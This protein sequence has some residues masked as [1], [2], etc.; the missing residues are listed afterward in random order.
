MSGAA[1]VVV[2][3]TARVSASAGFQ[4][5]Q[6]FEDVLIHTVRCNGVKEDTMQTQMITGRATMCLGWPIGREESGNMRIAVKRP[7]HFPRL[8]FQTNF[9]ST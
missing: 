3:M 5:V 6:L 9:T 4:F 1:I 2:S 8:N 7:S